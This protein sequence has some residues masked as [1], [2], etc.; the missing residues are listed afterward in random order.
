VKTILRALFLI[1]LGLRAT[2]PAAAAP[3]ADSAP[4]PGNVIAANSGATFGPLPQDATATNSAVQNALQQ[5]LEGQT[6]GTVAPPPITPPVT[7]AAPPLPLRQPRVPS[8]AA[9]QPAAN[10]TPAAAAPP[11]FPLPAPGQVPAAAPGEQLIAIAPSTSATNAS[12]E[13]QLPA[14]VINFPATDLN[15]VLQIYA[16]LVGR[17]VLRPTTLPAPTITLKTQTPLTKHEAIQAFDA[18]LALNGIAVINVGDKFV[19]VVPA[20]QA[21]QIGA[22]FSRAAADQ[23]PD[24]GQFVT[25]VIQL[26]NAKPSEVVQALTPFASAGTANGVLPID[27]SQILVLRDYAENVKRMLEMVKK[28]DVAIPSEYDSEVIPIK[29][30]LAADIANALNSLSSGGGGTTVGSSAAGGGV[31]GTRAGYGGGT[32]TGVGG[33]GGTTGFGGYQGSTMGGAT[34]YGGV[35]PQA[36]AQRTGTAG[37]SFTQRLQS[38]INRASTAGEIQV[39]GQTKIIADE[40]TNS[41]LIFASKE[42]LKVIK[43]IISQLDVVLAQVLIEAVIIQVT[44][45]NSSSLGVSYLEK[46]P[47]PQNG[48]FRGIGAINN[49]NILS[50]NNFNLIGSAATNAAG[51]VPGGFSYLASLGNDLDVSVSA[52]AANT[53]ARILQRPRIQTSHAVPASIFV[54]QSRP[55]PT[56]SYYGGGAYG[57]YSSIQQLQI[58]V[59]LEV[60][61]LINPDGLVVMDIHQKIDSFEG[62]VTIQN[63]GDVPITSEK[64]ASA[65]VAVRDH[66]TVMLGGLIETDKTSNNSGVPIFKDLPLLGVLFRASSKDDTRAELIVLIRPTVLPTPEVAALTARAEKDKMPEVRRMENEIRAEE[67]KRLHHAEDELNSS[68]SGSK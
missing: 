52:V 59:T 25:H 3:G 19:K 53:R 12:P 58:G 4:A 63:V 2:T 29:Y 1:G 44:L 47:H 31:G 5:A 46:Q 13:E 37:S 24:M 30:A 57:G 15:Q 14:G 42:D 55:Y 65:K 9:P 66:D 34:P 45:D 32:R 16:E 50:A 23:L 28:I 68:S 38:I 11:A 18:V 40:R 22:P 64:D 8:A 41:L 43:K 10:N 27:S 6:N 54:G 49:N 56:G 67:A 60:T 39:L 61:P 21:G 48:Y 35:N 17:T 33:F 51:S 7:N 36:S 20:G 62:N 26:T